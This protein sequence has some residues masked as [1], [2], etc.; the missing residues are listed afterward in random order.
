P[1]DD[2]RGRGAGEGPDDGEGI[3]GDEERH[4][5]DGS[6]NEPVREGDQGPVT[7]HGL[8]ALPQCP[9]LALGLVTG[10]ADPPSMP[11]TLPRP[12]RGRTSPTAARAR[13]SRGAPRST[14][15]H[16]GASGPSTPQSPT[17]SARGRLHALAS[18]GHWA[19]SVAVAVAPARSRSAADAACRPRSTSA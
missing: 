8:E 17:C 18:A 1:A 2:T 15:A 14:P 4:A 6:E 9:C 19:R 12:L 13:L 16:A 10:G 7:R 11:C 3:E 5:A